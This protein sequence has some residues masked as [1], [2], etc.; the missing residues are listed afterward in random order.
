MA[1]MPSNASGAGTRAKS[2]GSLGIFLDVYPSCQ[3]RL[4]A[5]IVSE[6]EGCVGI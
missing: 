5:P 2:P 6:K 1:H 3:E 4:G